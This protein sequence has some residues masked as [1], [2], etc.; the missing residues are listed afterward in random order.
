MA[1]TNGQV[2]FLNQRSDVFTR[3]DKHAKRYLFTFG[4]YGWTRCIV[5]ATSLDAALDEVVDWVMLCHPGL[6]CND[7]VHEEF[8]RIFAEKVAEGMGEEE[9]TEKALE[10]AEIDT[11]RLG[12]NGD[13]FASL[14]VN[15]A[16]NTSRALVKRLV[17]GL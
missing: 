4:A 5:W 17:E 16:E 7:E 8:E 11:V 1:H 10:E 15:Y 13:Y 14:E 12:R 9:A 6:S 3:A 2:T